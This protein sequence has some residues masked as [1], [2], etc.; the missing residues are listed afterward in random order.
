[1]KNLLIICAIMISLS[2]CTGRL[3]SYRKTV[4]VK[5]T[6]ASNQKHSGATR[7]YFTIVSAP[8]A[9]VST[10]NVPTTTASAAPINVTPNTVYLTTKPVP[11]EDKKE[12][13]KKKLSSTQPSS[14]SM[15]R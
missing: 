6:E 11:E 13:Q 7:A 14:S 3:Y 15:V 12:E 2:S 4:R 5:S 1:M 10:T 9:A 8:A